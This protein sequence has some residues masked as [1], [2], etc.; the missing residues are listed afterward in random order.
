ME[1]TKWRLGEILAELSDDF[2][3]SYDDKKKTAVIGEYEFTEYKNNELL[4]S[5]RV[6]KN[7][8][9]FEDF[10]DVIDATPDDVREVLEHSPD[11]RMNRQCRRWRQNGETM[12]IRK[13]YRV[14]VQLG[15]EVINISA[16]DS[17]RAISVARDAIVES[18][19][20]DLA[21]VAN[22]VAEEVTA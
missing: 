19:G 20:S 11:W 4:V 15:T 1:S 17:G 12:Y 6:Y 22:Y 13:E 14:I 3:I 16:Y 21:E 7:E 18:Y 9:W 5:Y 10:E 2:T 8:D